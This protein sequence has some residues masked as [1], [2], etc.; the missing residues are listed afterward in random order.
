[1]IRQRD[2]VSVSWQRFVWGVATILA[3]LATWY[4]AKQRANEQAI[5]LMERQTELVR[6]LSRMEDQMV[7]RDRLE[8]IL[9][10]INRRLERLERRNGG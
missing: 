1:M 6:R 7:S 9:R 2:V 3:I 10:E 8:D 4:N 5:I